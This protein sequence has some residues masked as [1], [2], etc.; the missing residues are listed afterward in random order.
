M[1]SWH[2]CGDCDPPHPKGERHR[3]RENKIEE[4][5]THTKLELDYKSRALPL[6]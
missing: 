1:P 2:L 5:V 6:N 4:E 3:K